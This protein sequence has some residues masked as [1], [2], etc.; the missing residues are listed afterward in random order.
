MEF[1]YLKQFCS[2][3][4]PSGRNVIQHSV[5]VR[6][7]CQTPS[8]D[9]HLTPIHVYEIIEHNTFELTVQVN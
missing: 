9:H 5:E 1:G 4:L 6:V 7:D 8:L 2:F 3:S